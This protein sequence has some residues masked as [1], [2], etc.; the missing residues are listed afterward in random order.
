MK[1]ALMGNIFKLKRIVLREVEISKNS[2][3]KASVN[4]K[5]INPNLLIAQ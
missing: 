1:I 4:I 2:K 3:R 5:K